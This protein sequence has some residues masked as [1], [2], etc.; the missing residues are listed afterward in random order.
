MPGLNRKWVLHAVFFLPGFE[1][2]SKYRSPA[3]LFERKKQKTVFFVAANY[4][5]IIIVFFMNDRFDLLNL[6]I[7]TI[8]SGCLPSPYPSFKI[9]KT[10]RFLQS[11]G[12]GAADATR[13]WQLLLVGSFGMLLWLLSSWMLRLKNIFR[14]GKSLRYEWKVCIYTL[15]TSF[16]CDI[17]YALSVYKRLNEYVCNSW[18]LNT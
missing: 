9:S 8:K 15:I 14:F 3:G 6:I 10:P 1:I 17:W 13:Q 7:A 4:S 12:K 18:I 2:P 11:C 16:I 5:L